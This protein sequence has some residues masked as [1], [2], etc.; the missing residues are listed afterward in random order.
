M[1]REHLP[2]AV[3]L[4]ELRDEAV[5]GAVALEPHHRGD[6]AR[7]RLP[8]V[9]R[10]VCELLEADREDVLAHADEALVTGEIPRRELPDLGPHRRRVAR[11]VEHGA[12]VKTDPVEGRHRDELHVI[13][14]LLPAELPELLEEEGRGDDGGPGVEREALLAEDAR[15]AARLV[16]PLEDGDVVAP[17]AEPDG[18][19]EPAEATADDDRVRL[20]RRAFGLHRDD[21]MYRVCTGVMQTV[22]TR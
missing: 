6:D 7:H 9:E 13:R 11:V 20:L 12:V 17:G 18:G 4:H 21:P 16:V 5:N 3:V 19:G 15:P 2:E 14:E 10:N 22:S 1:E 8:G